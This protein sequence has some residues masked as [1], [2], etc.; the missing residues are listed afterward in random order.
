MCLTPRDRGWIAS[1]CAV[2][3]LAAIL[4][5]LSP[6]SF[7]LTSVG[8]V[9]QCVLLLWVLVTCAAN[10]T[11]N[12]GKSRLFWG[13]MTLSFGFW[14][15]F[16]SLWTYFEVLVRREVPNPFVGDVILFLHLVPV[17]GAFA[18]Q[19]HLKRSERTGGLGVLDFVLLFVWWLYLY[20]FVVIPWQYVHF[21]EEVYGRSFDYVYFTEHGVVLLAAVILWVRSSG[22]W[23]TIYGHL[24]GASLLYALGSVA[25]SVAIDYG[26]YYTGSFY[27]VPIVAAMAWFGATAVMARRV[28]L[29]ADPPKHLEDAK[30]REWVAWMA[31]IT[32][33]SLPVL[34]AWTHFKSGALLE[35]RNFRLLLTLATIMV[36]G[37]VL[38]LKQY[39]LGKKLGLANLELEEASL[40]DLL[41]GVRNR[42]FLATTIESDIRHV[43]RATSNADPQSAANSDLIFYFVDVDHFK[44]VNDKHGHEAGDRVLVEI[45][46]RISTAIR[47]SDVLIRWGGEEFLVVSR[48]TNRK[49][50][51]VLAA[52]I[53]DGVGSEA[54]L[55]GDGESR[56]C[57]CS[58]GWAAF[59]WFVAAPEAVHYEK[60]LRLADFALYEA[61]KSGRNSAIGVLPSGVEPKSLAMDEDL[62]V[63]TLVTKGPC[64][65]STKA[66]GEINDQVFAASTSQKS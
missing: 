54:F 41:T 21:N 2:V 56:R 55:L 53:L 60:V 38:G 30:Q 19:P 62:T 33:L 15:T 25:A 59:P 14:L 36:M 17:M 16:Q 46:R 44:Q 22:N 45:A 40:T 42:R 57:T 35:V 65:E 9:T 49:E 23:K 24:L 51:D 48:Y 37:A 50:A 52:R 31:M 18:I 5:L 47:H 4:S 66:S 29:T 27:D 28:H 34:A 3:C 63:R 1:A 61:K 13:L 43:V 58:I 64:S 7:F 8:D 39:R 11:H 10:V 20:C 6:R 12:H 26:D 32:I